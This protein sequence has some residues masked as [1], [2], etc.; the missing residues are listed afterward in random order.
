MR[1]NK[2][3]TDYVEISSFIFLKRFNDV[4]GHPPSGVLYNK[5]LTL[6][7]TSL[8]NEFNFDMKL[9]HCWYRWGDVVV[10]QTLPYIGW[11]HSDLNNTA[12]SFN[13]HEPFIEMNNPIIKFI[14]EYAEDY[15]NRYGDDREG[16]ER[17]VDD[18]YLQAPLDFQR[19]YKTLRESLN[20]SR[21]N[22]PYVNQQEYIRS[23]FDKA[24]SSFPDSKF[25]NI[26]RQKNDFT[27][28]FKE[29]L[30]SN[31]PSNNLFDIA[32]DFW[33]FFCYHLRLKYNY[34]V[35]RGIKDAW[36]SKLML[37]TSR[38]NASI[39]NYAAQFCETS[40]DPTIKRLLDDRAK[41]LSELDELM[42]DLE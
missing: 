30:D 22:A 37:E 32:E 20:I 18:V 12:V 6:L 42:E 21:I 38:Y 5:F 35:G 19:N 10:K 40:D 17:A 8:K 28:V 27:A 39:Q 41:R 4:Y 24:M 11:T 26:I 9:P 31:V 1:V 23:L 29:C 14:V 3:N 36:K 7:N 34:N 13:G 25:K 33:F 16:V 2:S 15:L